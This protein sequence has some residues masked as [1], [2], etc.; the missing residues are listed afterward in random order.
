MQ[1][2]LDGGHGA[3]PCE[4]VESIK[5]LCSEYGRLLDL[6]DAQGWADLFA[7]EGEWVG[8][9]L[10]GVISGRDRLAAFVTKEFAATPP[11]VHMIGNFSIT[12]SDDGKEA[13]SWSRWM[14]VE[15]GEGGLRAALAG[16]YT[17]RLVKLPQGWRFQRREVAVDLPAG[18]ATEA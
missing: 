11:C 7:P 3:C 1:E 6:R 8:G 2:N 12:L 16:H 15:Q 5:R 14:L 18:A 9:E 17:D 4:D 10:Y 13:T